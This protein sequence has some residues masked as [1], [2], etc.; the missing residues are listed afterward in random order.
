[1][2]ADTG[3]LNLCAIGPP[4]PVVHVQVNF[5]QAAHYPSSTGLKSRDYLR[6][7]CVCNHKPIHLA[8]DHRAM[9]Q[10]PPIHVSSYCLNW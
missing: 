4:W 3:F 10:S 6:E 7:Q 9:C 2:T 5:H 1:M 8:R